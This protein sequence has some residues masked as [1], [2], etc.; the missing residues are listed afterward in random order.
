MA[1]ASWSS[2]ILTRPLQCMVS[3]SNYSW[4][5]KGDGRH[6]P[7][8]VRPP[9]PFIRRELDV[10]VLVRWPYAETVAMAPCNTRH[11]LGCLGA[12]D[13]INLCSHL[14][15]SVSLSWTHSLHRLSSYYTRPIPAL[16]E[17]EGLQPV[18]RYLWQMDSGNMVLLLHP[19]DP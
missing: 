10:T 7:S 3:T 12:Y 19:T 5:P 9:E 18:L 15:H 14:S 16:S 4:I 1:S 17:P 8:W 13:S 11:G 2:E 6:A